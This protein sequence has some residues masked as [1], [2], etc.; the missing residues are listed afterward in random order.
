MSWP[1]QVRNSCICFPGQAH[2]NKT[3]TNSDATFQEFQMGE[4]IF[5]A[6]A[7]GA[8]GRKLAPLLTEAGFTVYG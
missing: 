3:W 4:T 8:I 2:E 6:G 7:T 5:L 1:S